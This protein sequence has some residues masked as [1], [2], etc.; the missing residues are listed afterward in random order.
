VVA[1]AEPMRIDFER[2]AGFFFT[3]NSLIIGLSGRAKTWSTGFEIEISWT[4]SLKS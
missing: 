3:G 1:D 2:N 4:M